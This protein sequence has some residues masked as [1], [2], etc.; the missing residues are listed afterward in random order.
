MLTFD[1][2]IVQRSESADAY[3]TICLG[4]VVRRYYRLQ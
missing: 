4:Y 2:Q 3:L 1:E